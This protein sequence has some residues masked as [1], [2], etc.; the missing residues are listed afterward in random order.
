MKSKSH[1][2]IFTGILDRKGKPI[3]K[4]SKIAVYDNWQSKNKEEEDPYIGKI[5][6]KNGRYNFKND[7]G[8]SA[9]GYCIH[10]WRKRIEVLDR[11]DIILFHTPTMEEA[12]DKH[13]FGLPIIFEQDKIRYYLREAFKAGYEAKIEHNVKL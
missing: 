4:N 12:L 6:W 5:V 2:S 8:T 10:S 3:Y 11:N 1:E 9:D 7:N 13:M